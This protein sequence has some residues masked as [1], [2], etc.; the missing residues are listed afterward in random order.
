VCGCSG[1]RTS[2][3]GQCVDTQKDPNNCGA[4][5]VVCAQNCRAGQC[6]AS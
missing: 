6:V 2:C 4:C 1:G 5:G 3:G